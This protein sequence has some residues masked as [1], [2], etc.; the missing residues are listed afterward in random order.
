MTCRIRRLGPAFAL[1]ALL[2][3]AAAAAPA[4]PT[5]PPASLP[6]AAPGADAVLLDD[7]VGR[8]VAASG[9]PGAAAALVRRDGRVTLRGYGEADR[10][11]HHAVDAA[12]TVFRV[13]SI[14]KTFTALAVLQLVEEGKVALDADANRYL[15][16]VRIPAGERPV[17]VLDLFTHRSSFDADLSF[18]GLDDPAAA[19]RS[20]DARLQRDIHRLRP[21]GEVAAY[22]N[23]AW[24]LLGHIVESVDGVPYAEAIARRIFRPLGMGRSQVGLPPPSPGVAL[25][26]EVDAQG[27]PQRRPQMYLRRGW[28]GAGDI[29]TTAA[30]M[31]RF[32]GALLAEGQ[33]PGGRLLSAAGFRRFA[34]TT[35]FSLTPGLPGTGLGVYALG[36][37][38][39]GAFGHAGTIRGFNALFMV[40]PREGLALFAVMNL[41]KAVPEMTVGGLYDYLSH[42]PGRVPLDP[43][44]YMLIDL[45]ELLAQ[46]LQ[47]APALAPEAAPAI[48]PDPAVDWSGR[49]AGLRMQSYEALLPRVAATLFIPPRVVSRRPDGLLQIGGLGP[50][51]PIA[52]NLYALDRPAGPLATLIGFA[53]IGGE[54]LMAPHTLQASRRLAAYERPLLTVGGLLLAPLL[55]LA[56]ALLHWRLSRAGSARRD[57]VLA[58]A[59][60][61]VLA[62]LATEMSAAAVLVRVHDLGAVVAAWRVV[63]NLALLT[64]AW[65][66]GTAAWRAWT[67]P[68]TG[69]AV[70]AGRVSASLMA[71]LALWALAA[72]AYW[73]VLGRF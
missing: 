71:L 16:G 44:D 7:L 3:L 8:H 2:W 36:R 52:P 18:V 10:A 17:R 11:A 34:D 40:M 37:V 61:L 23:M 63:L 51:R 19:A 69:D 12:T 68:R 46:R 21:T 33:Y 13:G 64:L 56:G 58:L 70:V 67:A 20:G 9:I 54:A 24:G 32:L 49:Y 55:L 38:G 42:P 59:A 43:T 73:H 47:T 53:S 5:T 60:L 35:A 22:D 41:N 1:G 4:T 30:D 28:Q 6:G 25:A 14:S 31:S 48:Q 50:Y 57:G 65:Q 27:R 45:P 62:G 26:Y 66:A 72:A 15:K 29:S 39:G